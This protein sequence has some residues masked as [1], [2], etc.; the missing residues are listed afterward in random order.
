VLK[1][2][3]K[4]LGVPGIRLG[5]TYSHH[6]G[7]N[8]AMARGVPIWQLNS[9]AEFLLEISLKRR[10]EYADSIARTCRDREEFREALTRVALVDYVAPSG[11]NFLF[12]R[13]RCTAAQAE[14]LCADLLATDRIYV[15]NVS[16]KIADG[17]G[18][19]RA[20]VRL[21]R[22]NERFCTALNTAARRLRLTA[23]A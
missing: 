14:A 19:L 6:A 18:H 15:K 11:A 10:R 22:E 16:D 1:S 5:Y 13:L 17:S 23:A 9:V 12:L 7:F 3:S 20:A 2:L 4:T 8:A 21:P